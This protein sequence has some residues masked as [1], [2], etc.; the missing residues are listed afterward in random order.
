MYFP[1]GI[2]KDGFA[3]GFGF[4]QPTAIP[5]P[6]T[7]SVACPVAPWCP[8]LRYCRSRRSILQPRQTS[9][10]TCSLFVYP[11]LRSF[12]IIVRPVSALIRAGTE[13]DCPL[14]VGV[15][16]VHVASSLVTCTSNVFSPR[17]PVENINTSVAALPFQ[18]EN[19][20]GIFCTFKESLA[21][22]PILNQTVSLSLLFFIVNAVNF[23]VNPKYHQQHSPVLSKF[24]PVTC[25]LLHAPFRRLP[26]FSI[27]ALTQKQNYN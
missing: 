13:D 9:T 27:S 18:L 10:P 6:A 15:K 19:I 21:T 7:S 23:L 12:I 1:T 11:E 14:R 5:P 20:V 25:L 26:F 4:V 16:H 17:Y 3:Q 22:Q 8:S 2:Y 24:C